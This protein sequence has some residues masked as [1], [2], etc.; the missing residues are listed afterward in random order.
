MCDPDEVKSA[1]DGICEDIWE[2]LCNPD[3][4][5]EVDDDFCDWL[6]FTPDVEWIVDEDGYYYDDEDEDYEDEY[7]YEGRSS[8]P[9]AYRKGHKNLRG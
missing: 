1:D 2:A 4:E 7:A 5:I 8:V 6:G 9:D 3:Q